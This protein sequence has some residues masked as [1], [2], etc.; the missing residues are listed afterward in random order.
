VKRRGEWQGMVTIVRLNWPYYLVAGITLLATLIG[1]LLRQSIGVRLMCGVALAASIYFLVGSLGVSHLIYDRSD[2]YRFGWVD[3]ALRGLQVNDAIFCH[4]GFDEMS[5]ELR[6]KLGNIGW[7]NLDHFD[8]GQMTE[9]SIRRARRRYPPVEGTLPAPHGHWPI[10]ADAADV[11]FGVLAIHELRSDPQRAA[12]FAEARRCLRSGGRLI[13]V[14][15]LRDAANLLAFGPGFL[16]FHSR[17]NWRRSW[18][19]AG[20]RPLDEFRITPWVRVFVL[21]PK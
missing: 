6:E 15:H 16:H 11:I 10:S 12:W 21:T 3:R 18:E 5:L 19:S 8:Q 1:I 14:E 7:Q 20:F 9:A 17:E 2:L 4:S 13:L